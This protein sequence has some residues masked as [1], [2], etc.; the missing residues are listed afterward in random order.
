M[1]LIRKLLLL[2]Y[3]YLPSSIVIDVYLPIYVLICVFKKNIV[4]VFK[5]LYVHLLLVLLVTDKR[6]KT[7]TVK[8]MWVDEQRR[9][10]HNILGDDDDDSDVDSDGS[11]E[12]LP[13]WVRGEQRWV[14]G[15]VGETTCQDVITVLLQDEEV[16]VSNKI[17]VG[18]CSGIL[19]MSHNY[20]LFLF[21]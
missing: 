5:Y 2:I 12:E 16:R 15:V 4:A 7:K 10:G 17:L 19:N 8:M 18:F 3:K 13:I 11:G 9:T 6:S 20:C 21:C 14:S 1:D